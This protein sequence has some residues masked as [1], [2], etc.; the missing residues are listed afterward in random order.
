MLLTEQVCVDGHP[1][2]FIAWCKNHNT[3]VF[4][5]GAAGW[6][7]D[8]GIGSAFFLEEFALSEWAAFLWERVGESVSS[9]LE[10]AGVICDAKGVIKW[11]GDTIATWWLWITDELSKGESCASVQEMDPWLHVDQ[12]FNLTPA[13][14]PNGNHKFFKISGC[15]FSGLYIYLCWRYKTKRSETNIC[16]GSSTCQVLCRVLYRDRDI[17]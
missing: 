12:Q 8:F 6:L 13:L 5:T 4:F 7:S 11:V 9:C 10:S 3:W 1:V 2:S 17:S 14:S 16:R 15:L